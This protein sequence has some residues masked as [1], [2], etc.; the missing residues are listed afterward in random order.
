M[1]VAPFLSELRRLDIRVWLEG[2]SLRCDA[3]AGVLS[4]EL[5]EHLRECKKDIISFLQMA[6]AV[7]TQSS[8]IVP[9]QRHGSRAPVFAVPGHGGDV[10]CFRELAG[11][12]GPEQPFFGLQPPGLDGR[13]HPLS[14]I[15]DLAAYF[16]EQIRAFRPHGP[17]IVAGYC[18]GGT[19][20]F[21]LARRLLDAPGSTGTLA[22]FGAPHP[23]FFRPLRF[24]RHRLEYRAEGW[25]RRARLLA[26]QSNRERLEYVMWR[27]RRND[28]TEADPILRLRA[29]VEEATLRALRAY[30]PRPFGG[31][32]QHFIACEAWGR[33]V[34]VE[35]WRSVAP[36]LETY[37]GPHGCTGDDML[38]T[39]HAPVFAEQFRH[40]LA[41]GDA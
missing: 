15:E 8:A 38:Q 23:A 25:R 20:A 2:N 37:A 26:G 22:L 14:R 7:A 34:R 31:R 41:R 17:W 21:E 9:L 28:G 39:Q 33:H 36:R 3:P 24:L 1:N 27:M 18:S 40:A 4:D 16:A 35:R 13:S 6:D 10:F 32:V 12:L 11:A 5:R 19:V 29:R 30:E